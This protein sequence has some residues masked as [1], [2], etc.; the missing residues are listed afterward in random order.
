MLALAGQVGRPA[1]GV[2]KRSDGGMVMEFWVVQ[3]Q[4]HPA[5]PRSDTNRREWRSN[6]L[7]EVLADRGH[8]VTR[9]RSSFSH[10]QKRQLTEGSVLRRGDG[11]ALQYIEARSYQRHVGLRR[12]LSHRSLAKNFARLAEQWPTR[13]DLIH[14]G[15][16]PI[17]LGLSA[18]RYG[19][20]HDI[21]VIVDVRDLWPDLYLDLVPQRLRRTRS[22]ANA[23]LNR[24]GSAARE[25]LASA[26]SV[27]ALTESYLSW[28][29][30]KAGR[31]RSELD[32]VF[33]MAN[34][35]VAVEDLELARKR[36]EA[37]LG[38]GAA[39]RAL[40]V[41]AGNLGV[42]SEF[43]AAIDG[44]RL[45]AERCPHLLMVL[46]GDGPQLEVLRR[47][48]AGSQ[49]V[50]L[51][52]WLRGEDLSALLAIASVG[53]V[54]YKDTSNFQLNVPNKFP[55]Y[56]G[57]GLAIACSVGG[58]MGRLV[59]EH[60]CGFLYRGSDPHDLSRRLAQMFTDPS[61]LA[62]QQRSASLLHRDRFS[63]DVVFPAFAD[64]LERIAAR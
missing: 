2:G 24:P 16:V 53:L 22:V 20:L 14:V 55:E 63:S 18:V 40:V 37:F 27:T 12:V 41:Y 46:A 9:W 23:F 5:E 35:P 26:T 59:R 28:A 15:N 45:A 25:A 47:H 11:C 54:P 13:P 33:P 49:N 42:Q 44:A 36:V 60:D 8:R 52:G 17:E 43:E 3:A 62:R 4:E 34:R 48:A 38:R 32:A 50:V 19:K 58:E 57:A 61:L 29:L 30:E 21:P 56:L 31:D 1:T 7:A 6:T 10:H 64:H 39:E 51:P